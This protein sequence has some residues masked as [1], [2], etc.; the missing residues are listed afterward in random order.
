[1]A[2]HAT[3][4]LRKLR[5]STARFGDCTD[6]K[7]KTAKSSHKSSEQLAYFVCA[8]VSVSVTAVA[9]LAVWPSSPDSGGSSQ[10]KSR[11]AEGQYSVY[12]RVSER[13][14]DKS[15]LSESGSV[16]RLGVELD[17]VWQHRFFHLTIKANP[18]THVKV[19]SHIDVLTLA[20]R[21][22]EHHHRSSDQPS[23]FHRHQQADNLEP[24][25]PRGEIG[26][27]TGH[28]LCPMML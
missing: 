24:K 27:S 26:S 10:S 9:R 23:K 4:N 20:T 19:S 5:G 3:F 1:M 2:R 8:C 12:E 25:D 18:H 22:H 14:C 28:Q 17:I 15:K 13:Q 11:L 16:R 7:T 21:R 6:T